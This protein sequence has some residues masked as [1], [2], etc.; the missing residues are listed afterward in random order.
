MR[1][2]LLLSGGMDS[3]CLAYWMRPDLAIN[4]DYG[5]KPAKA[6]RRAAQEV[7]TTLGIPLVLISVD[8][9][10]LGSGDLAGIEPAAHA[11][12][13]EW[14]P[15]R[16]QL[17]VTLAIMAAVKNDIQELMIGTLKTDGIHA[18][19][20]PEFIDAMDRLCQLQEGGIRLSAPAIQ[21][22]AVELVKHARVPMEI[23]AW[24]HSCHNGNL[25]CGQC[26]GCNKHA[27]TYDELAN[28]APQA[29]E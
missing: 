16:N 7:A 5:Q 4:I 27:N 10:S 13:S 14:W 17:I 28:F 22:S 8:C 18:D 1:T 12:S 24:S 26:R 25:A 21:F 19:G 29:S 2:A 23:L 11:P 3:I 20:R 6:E 9:A 15:F